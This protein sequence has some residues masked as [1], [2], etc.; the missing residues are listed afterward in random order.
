MNNI[1]IRMSLIEHDLK[2]W[3]LASILNVSESQVSRMLRTELPEEEQDRII[4]K[5][6]EVI[7]NG[8]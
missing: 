1:K 3:E 8:K 4:A 6:E 2:Q 7:S 5:I